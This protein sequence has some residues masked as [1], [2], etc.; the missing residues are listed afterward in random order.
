MSVRQV[1]PFID[2]NPFQHNF[3]KITHLRHHPSINEYHNDLIL[4]T[5]R[6]R[7]SSVACL[8]FCIQG[9]YLV[10]DILMSWLVKMMNPSRPKWYLLYYLLAA[11][12]VLTV[13]VGLYL[14]HRIMDIYTRS[15][16]V[17]HQWAIRLTQY[18]ELNQL[19]AAVNAPGNDVFDTHNVHTESQKMHAALTIFNE[20]LATLEKELEENPVQ[21]SVAPVLESFRVIKASMDEMIAEAELIFSYFKRNQPEMAGKRMA[22]MDRDY[23]HV[24]SAFADL[25]EQVGVIQE[26]LFNEQM[27]T[28]DSLQKFEYVIGVSILLMVGGATFY[29]HK[30][31]KQIE[32]DVEEKENLIKELRE[33]EEALRGAKDELEE[34]VQE[35]TAALVNANK[36]LQIEITERKRT[37]EALA[38][39]A[40]RDALTN[41]YNRRHFN[42][43]M[44]EEIARADRNKHT[45]AILLCDLD[46][47]KTINDTHGHQAGDEVLRA[48]AKG[49]QRSTRGTDFAFRWGGD[50]IVVILSEATREGVL[51]AAERIRREV[52]TISQR[53]KLGLDI[54]IGVALYP[55]HGNSVDALIRLADRALYIAKKGGDKIHIGEEEYHLDE[56]TIRVMFQPVM[57]LHSNQIIGYE[58]LSR[59]AQGKL[60]ILE[61]YKRYQAIGQLNELKC[62]C[63]R[64]QLKAAQEIGLNRVFMNVDFTMLDQLEFIP[65]PSD[66]EVIL[67]ISEVEALHDVENHLKVARKWRKAGYQFAIDDFGAG[68]ISLPF[69]ATL[70]PDYIKLDRSTILQAVSSETFRQ[71]SKD[72]VRALKN[73]AREGIIA[74]GIETQ[75]ELKVVKEMGIYIVQGFL[76]GKPQELK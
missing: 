60:S 6:L 21:D 34:K 45:L 65:K 39:Q 36:E 49:I 14:N 62:L 37:E 75:K 51:I 48:M 7:Q 58:A 35:R 43:R 72:L 74:E 23:A 52:R 20:H 27:A 66:L 57:D 54:S 47:F 61:L 67:E 18:S 4:I 46:H 13:S 3:L 69:I 50:E 73:Y 8:T 15:V 24:N 70:I 68:F 31:A 1:A 10:N 11:F 9:L 25:R 53:T 5:G 30:I 76:L 64:S 16:G 19:A 26:D 33:A 55:E 29:G 38:E 59:D 28:A 12:D 22:T 41:L 2:I 56:H 40:I 17:N 42:S 71:F 32:L 63:F 44:E